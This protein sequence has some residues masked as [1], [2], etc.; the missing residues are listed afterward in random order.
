MMIRVELSKTGR[1]DSM[2]LYQLRYFAKA[3]AYG[4]I[5]MAAQDLHVTQP[6]ISKA[7]KALEKELQVELMFRNGKYCELTH[8]GRQLQ[9]RLK[10]ILV[11]LDEIPMELRNGHTRHQIQLNALSAGLLVPEL[12]RKFREK[13][14]KVYF[15][16]LDRREAIN[17]DFCIR[18]TL[19]EVFFNN[20]VKLMEEKMFLACRKDSRLAEKERICLSD[21]ANEDFVMLR[22]GGSIREIADKRFKDLGFIPKLS[23]ECD[24]LFILKRVVEE[25][26][27]VTIWPEF[28]WRS[29]MEEG[30]R[31]SEICL[32]PLDIP[33]FTRSLYLIRQKDI[34]MTEEMEAFSDFTIRYFLTIDKK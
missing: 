29:R 21:L 7:I 34:K 12:I 17:W 8:E 26:L 1:N 15:R 23:Y 28:S 31:E 16:I 5:S 13:Y 11:E 2:E 30:I 6:S 14:P 24:N 22:S 9:A 18:S 4:N 27:G 25:G 32:K 10:P 20:A 3:A 19:P 33:E